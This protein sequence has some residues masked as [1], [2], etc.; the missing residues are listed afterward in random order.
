VQRQKSVQIGRKEPTCWLRLRNSG[1]FRP[2]AR[3]TGAVS[4][5]WA[6]PGPGL[7]PILC[8]SLAKAVDVE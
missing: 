6:T 4:R 1:H 7:V 2:M 8:R 5:N 3:F